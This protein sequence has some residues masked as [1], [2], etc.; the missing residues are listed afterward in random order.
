MAT[1]VMMVTHFALLAMDS[2]TDQLLPQEI[3]LGVVL[4]SLTT[5]ASTQRMVIIWVLH[6]ET[7]Q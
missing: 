7:Y 1:T 4:I 3:S 5:L 6:L 2:H